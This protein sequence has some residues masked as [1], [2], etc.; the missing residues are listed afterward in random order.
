MALHNNQQ[1][2]NV[3]S[4]EK[5]TKPDVKPPKPDI[6]IPPVGTKSTLKGIGVEILSETD[7][8]KSSKGE[9]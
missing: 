4:T 6:K 8:H 2:T 5:E 3:Q 7:T 1:D 9:R